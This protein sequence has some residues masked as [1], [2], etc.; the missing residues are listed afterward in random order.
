MKCRVQTTISVKA[1][2]LTAAFKP[3]SHNCLDTVSANQT[4]PLR[5]YYYLAT[6]THPN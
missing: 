5:D 2:L 6:I 4:Y 1:E 3:I